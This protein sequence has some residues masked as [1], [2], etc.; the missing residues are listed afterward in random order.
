MSGDTT[1]TGA[2]TV[3]AQAEEREGKR[4]LLRSAG[5]MSIMTATSRIF[6]LVRDM[7]MAALMG[8]GMHMDAFRVANVIPNMLRRLLGE[9]AMTAAFIPTFAQVEQKGDKERLW[10]FVST[11]FCTFALILLLTAALGVAFSPVLVDLITEQ[12]GFDQVPGKIELTIQLNQVMFPY[13]SLIGLAAIVMA[14]LNSLGSFG[15]PAFTP[16]LFN[17]SIIVCGWAFAS[18]FTSPAFGFAIGVLLG[19]LAQIVFQLPF[20][21][22]FS[23]KF[24]F[25]VSFID[26]EIRQVFKLMVPGIFAVGITQ[27]NIFI[28]TRVLT[29]LEEGATSGIYYSDRLMELTLGIFAISVSTVILPLLSR[30]A[31]AGR[32]EELRQTLSFAIRVVGFITIPA[33]VGLIVLRKP[34]VSI[35]FQRGA[36]DERSLALTADPLVF[37]SLGLFLFAMIKVMAPAFYAL[38]EMRIPVMISSCDMVVNITLCYILSAY[39][40]NSGV[41]LALTCGAALNVSLLLF[42][43]IRRHG[44]LRFRQ[45]CVSLVKIAVASAVMGG[46]CWLAGG[47]LGLDSMPNGW[48]KIG[49]T[50]ATIAAGVVVFSIVCAAFRSRELP[51]LISMFRKDRA[52]PGRS[53][54]EA[55]PPGERPE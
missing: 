11:F 25:R 55:Q 50:L 40:G 3:A 37:F 24:N 14:V 42:I 7:S 26:P 16:V 4:R 33:A 52:V 48:V 28:A 35:V 13:I 41:A 38:K 5:I 45:I 6:G 29:G 27:I 32:I 51:E 2:E 30:Q 20:L 39:M 43:F 49:L 8:T 34:I 31:A 9:G 46:F 21:R 1:T 15:P 47:W 18:T 44:S 53:S 54:A 17:I 22:R 19:G 23:V 36:F 10:R 12:G